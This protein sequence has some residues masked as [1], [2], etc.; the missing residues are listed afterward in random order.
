MSVYVH[1]Y[2]LCP[3]RRCHRIYV[4]TLQVSSFLQD[5]QVLASP[6][7]LLAYSWNVKTMVLRASTRSSRVEFR[8][9]IF[10]YKYIK[11]C[12]R[13][14][15]TYFTHNILL[16]IIFTWFDVVSWYQFPEIFCN[17][18]FDDVSVLHIF[19]HH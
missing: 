5:F 9:Y 19:P 17:K 15:K 10:I 6:L 12:T 4:R 1:I 16:I 8:H 18:R 2:K 7:I 3:R 14:Y 13:V 11:Y